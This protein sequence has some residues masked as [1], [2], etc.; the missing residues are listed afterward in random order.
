MLQRRTND[1]GRGTHDMNT[2]SDHK[3]LATPPEKIAL[4]L[5]GGGALGSYQ[6][7]VY[8]AL[9]DANYQPDWVAGISI[10][11]INAAIIAGNPPE[12]RVA[13]LRSF[14]EQITAT[15]VGWPLGSFEALAS[16][17]QRVYAQAALLF[18]QP[19]FFAPRKALEWISPAPPISYYDTNALKATLERLVDFDRINAAD[20]PRLSVGAVNVRTGRFAYF[21]STKI[22]IRPEHIMAS[23]ALPP[24]FP[25]VEIDG[26]HYWDGGVVSNTPLAYVLD[27]LPRRSRLTFQV[28]VFQAYGPVPTTLEGV[29]EREKD[30]RYASRTRMNT[31][32]HAYKH[33]VRHAINELIELL[34]PELA[35]TPEAQ[36]LYRLG[37]VTQMDIVQLIYRPMTPQGSQKDYEFSRTTMEQRWDQ[38]LLDAQQTLAA[39]PWLAPKG[40]EVGVRVFDVWHAQMVAE[41]E[42][43]AALVNAAE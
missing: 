23:G 5:Q 17:H 6:A 26:E 13:Q 32:I 27:Q 42:A 7:G 15:A 20:E 4:V 12:T 1:P 36:K 31:D 3:G 21:D 41:R 16:V 14:W 40:K 19:G 34:P 29:A 28:D 8:A 43:A 18:G 30:I 25:A 2:Q 24:G 11:G 39:A 38:G 33:E 37:C 9:A 35:N 10:G 22:T